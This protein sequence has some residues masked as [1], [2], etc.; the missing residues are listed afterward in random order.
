MLLL[1]L[2]PPPPPPP[3]ALSS[4]PL[5][6]LA[7]PHRPRAHTSLSISMACSRKKT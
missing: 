7:L 4:L 5:L 2:L 6:L 3:L 1:L